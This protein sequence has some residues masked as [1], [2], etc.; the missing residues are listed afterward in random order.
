MKT[1]VHKWIYKETD[2]VIENYGRSNS[3]CQ[4]WKQ[5]DVYFCEKCLEEK[6]VKKEWCGQEHYSDRPEWT[7]LGSF[8][9]KT[10]W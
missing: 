5:T 8:R 4:T 6:T 2:R 1:C 10:I 3:R 9:Q 7:K